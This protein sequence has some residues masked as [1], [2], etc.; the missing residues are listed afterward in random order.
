MLLLSTSSLKWYWIHRICSFVKKSNYDWLDLYMDT[1]EYDLW[2]LEY[3]KEIKNHY[4][5]NILSITACW[6]WLNKAKVNIIL[7]IAKELKVEVVTF[8]PP[9]ITDKDKTWFTKYLQEVKN[10]FDFVISIQNVE[11]KYIFFIIPKYKNMPLVD[12]KKITWYASLDVA[13]INNES[14][15]DIIKAIWLLWNSLKNIYLSDKKLDKYWL[16][17]WKEKSWISNLPIE[18]FLMQLKANSYN[19]FITIKV[20]PD[21]LWV[22]NEEMIL[23][24]LDK[25]KNYYNK[26]Y[27][28]FK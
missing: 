28:N 1:N 26:Y 16:L 21:E 10:D 22:W 19:W 5:I 4:N 6:E 24:N 13:N 18:S 8:S 2:D 7:D 14:S 27:L 15:I 11:S 12:I 17:P 23:K 25:I 9:H 3:L 20:N